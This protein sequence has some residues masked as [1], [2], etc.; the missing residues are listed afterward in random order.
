MTLYSHDSND[1]ILSRFARV[2]MPSINQNG[3]VNPFSNT[4]PGIIGYNLTV[5]KKGPYDD[6]DLEQIRSTFRK[7]GSYREAA[8]IDIVLSILGYRESKEMISMALQERVGVFH[9]QVTINSRWANK[10]RLSKSAKIDDKY[11]L[12]SPLTFMLSLE[13]IDGVISPYT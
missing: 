2:P 9:D 4:N 3:V 12:Q 10:D 11:I 6:R 8:A 13:E 1:P 5:P 7:S